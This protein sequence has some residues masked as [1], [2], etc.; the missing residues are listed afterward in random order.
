MMV[1]DELEKLF[2]DACV[3]GFWVTDEKGKRVE[4]LEYIRAITDLNKKE[5]GQE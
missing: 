1:D 2:D 3:Y 4:P 5:D